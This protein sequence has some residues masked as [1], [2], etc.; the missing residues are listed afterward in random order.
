MNFGFPLMLLF[1]TAVST[2]GGIELS[3]E[4][5]IIPSDVELTAFPSGMII[6][7]GNGREYGQGNARLY[8]D[9]A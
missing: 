8:C 6:Q 7:A 3:Q 1:F 4:K 2:G 9:D 5:L